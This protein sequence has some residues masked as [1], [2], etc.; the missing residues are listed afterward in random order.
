MKQ[1]E[2]PVSQQEDDGSEGLRVELEVLPIVLIIGKFTKVPEEDLVLALVLGAI[3]VS[4]SVDSRRNLE[5]VDVVHEFLKERTVLNVDGSHV[6]DV[7][8][9]VEE[10]VKDSSY[11]KRERS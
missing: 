4:A 10:L 2:Q 3:H 6:P 8:D 5:S 7:V 11:R 1:L 9:H